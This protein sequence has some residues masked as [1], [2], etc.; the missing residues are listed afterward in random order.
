MHS[1]VLKVVQISDINNSF[2]EEETHLYKDGQSVTIAGIISSRVDKKTRAGDPMA[3]VTIED[4]YSEIEL[5]VFPKVLDNYRSL[6][7]VDKPIAVMGKIS[8]SDDKVPKILVEKAI[9][10]MPNPKGVSYS[11]NNDD[12]T[13]PVEVNQDKEIE[14]LYLKLKTHD[15]ALMKRI[16][17]ISSL[18]PG[19]TSLILFFEDTKKTAVMQGGISINKTLIELF[20]RM[21]GND[22][23]AT[24]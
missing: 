22:S 1:K 4:R 17:V 13:E 16:A 10:L 12:K 14:K 9:A 3:F 7:I 18:F 21:L 20:S 11:G 8:L 23:I 6:F 2:S 15:E 19:S 24:K 5:V